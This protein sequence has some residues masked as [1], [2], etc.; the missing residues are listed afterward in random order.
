MIGS[1]S[2]IGRLQQLETA[3]D[4]MTNELTVAGWIGR[5]FLS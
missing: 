4:R 5:V 1:Y 3:G 2:Q